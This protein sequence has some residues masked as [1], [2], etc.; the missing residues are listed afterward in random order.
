MTPEASTI[1]FTRSL[2]SGSASCRADR[3]TLRASCSC[4]SRCSFQALDLSTCL[5]Q[6]PL[7]DGDDEPGLL[8][9]VEECGRQQAARESGGSNAASASTP[10]DVPVGGLDDRLV[11]DDELVVL[12]R[13]AEVGFCGGALPGHGPDR[14]VEHLDLALAAAGLGE[15]HG[16]V[17]VAEQPS[18]LRS[19][20]SST[21][22]PMLTPSWKEWPAT[23]NG[24]CE[25]RHDPLR[26]GQHEVAVV[27]LVAGDDELV[28]AEPRQ[29]VGVP[30]HAR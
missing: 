12:E 1:A 3:F 27:E 7:T 4:G 22:T 24:D 5:G 6:H 25:H 8:G 20:S 21:A 30:E 23:T 2:R 18:R 26:E 19:S 13:V 15:V 11:V 16:G 28:A 14:L 17:G 10:A 29:G 9:Q